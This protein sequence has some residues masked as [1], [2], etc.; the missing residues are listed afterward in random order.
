MNLNINL[1]NLFR[2]NEIFEAFSSDGTVDGSI[3]LSLAVYRALFHS[4]H[5]LQRICACLCEWVLLHRNFSSHTP[6]TPRSTF[7]VSVCNGKF[8][9]PRKAFA[10]IFMSYSVSP[11]FFIQYSHGPCVGTKEQAR[12]EHRRQRNLFRS[13]YSLFYPDL[14]GAFCRDTSLAVCFRKINPSIAVAEEQP[15]WM[16]RLGWGAFWLRTKIFPG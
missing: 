4:P 5:S 6:H 1:K 16:I 13:E 10:Y 3:Q 8:D 12:R 9:L 2:S 15:K 7:S 14:P 11:Q